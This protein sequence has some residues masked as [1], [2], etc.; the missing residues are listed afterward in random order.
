MVRVV[1][2]LFVILISQT[3]FSQNNWTGYEHLFMPVQTYVV[4][5]TPSKIKIDGI[6]DELVWNNA[7]WTAYLT[8]IEGG[9][10][11]DPACKTRCKIL[12]D[13]ENLYIYAEM[14]EPHVWAYYEKKDMIVYHE[15][16]FEVFIDPDR[17][18]HNY[19][20]FEINAQNTLF[21]LFLPKPYRNGGQANIEW[22][23]SG[24]KSAVFIDGTLNDPSDI[25]KMWAVE[26]AIPFSSLTTNNEYVQPEKGKT[27]KIGFSRVQ[28][29]IEIEDG[30]YRKKKDKITN[31]F[32]PEDNWVWS[33]QG[34]VNM[35]YPE[36]WGMIQFAGTYFDNEKQKF[37]FPIEEKLN[38][39]LWL[40]Y[41][42]QNQFK[43]EN[44]VFAESLTKLEIPKNGKVDDI[45]FQLELKTG[46]G[47]F[48]AVL[49]TENGKKL[50]L[51]QSG[52]FQ[53]LNQ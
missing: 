22:N 53:I 46:D 6:P 10:K 50:S 21:D 45:L 36:R 13:N 51:N 2:I 7:D 37:K 28:W 11:V 30:M 12:W 15:N 3:S 41:Y 19:F 5:Q 38:D 20:E 42:K 8:D 17:S 43:K 23:S 49:E 29:Q 34:L 40:I 27:W 4:H 14:E 9:K 48:I 31:K 39:Y 44:G 18:T 33:P 24:F 1:F 16:D 25:D 52:Y 26:M 35:H 47:K 32:F